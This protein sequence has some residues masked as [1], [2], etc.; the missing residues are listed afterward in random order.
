MEDEAW[1]LS[2]KRRRSLS[3]YHYL[4][5]A[6]LSSGQISKSICPRF[7]REN[8]ERKTARWR[9]NEWFVGRRKREKQRNTWHRGGRERVV[10]SQRTGEK[11]EWVIRRQK[12]GQNAHFLKER[13]VKRKMSYLEGERGTYRRE[14]HKKSGSAVKKKRRRNF[15][16]EEQRGSRG[17]IERK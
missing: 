2:V 8:R 10:F 6:G 17:F 13:W 3:L 5:T 1:S 12:R 11:W 16:H 14:N 15:R 4:L 9:G 7:H